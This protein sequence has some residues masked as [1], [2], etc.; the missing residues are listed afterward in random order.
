MTLEINHDIKLEQKQTLAMTPQ[1]IQAIRIL[2]YNQQELEEFIE[3]QL[4][5]NPVL[6]LDLTGETKDVNLS[7]SEES[8]EFNRNGKETAE[9]D[10]FDWLEFINEREYDDVSYTYMSSEYSSG[11]AV[12]EVPFEK[13]TYEEKTLSEYLSEQLSISELTEE[14]E[15]IALNIID[16]L[17]ENG[18]MTW[19]AGEIAR[20]MDIMQA[21]VD[22]VIRIIQKFE[23]IGVCASDLIECLLLQMRTMEWNDKYA[24]RIVKNHLS[25]IGNNKLTKVAKSLKISVKK[26]QDIAEKI[27]GL[28]P[29]PGRFFGRESDTRYI[30]PDVI[31]EKMEDGYSISMN[32]LNS[33]QLFINPYYR[34]ILQK[35]KGDSPVTSFITDRLN[36]ASWLIKS[37]E[38]RNQTIYNVVDALVRYQTEFF[39]RGELWIKPLT[40]RK[41]ADE[42]GMSESTVSRA[43]CGKYMQSP[44]G[45]FELKYFFSGGLACENGEDVA[46]Q[47][48]KAIIREIVANEDPTSPVSDQAIA[49]RLERSGVDISRRTVAK[50]R[51]SLGIASSSK[52]RRY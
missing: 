52:R 51:A 9:T 25:D 44:R 41:I 16:S 15:K 38:Q 13:S 11:G 18:Y 24:E 6:E 36:S 32:G 30:I 17:D 21:R 33:P 12:G 42:I 5:N 40:L 29:K 22:H 39:E 7:V 47:S 8:E 14:D 3:E 2:Q 26:V 34:K 19:S 20:D 23:P 49:Q 28:D 31:I 1:L 35:E 37:I 4:E 46:S 48:V 10:D 45:V 27:R 50:Y 43:V